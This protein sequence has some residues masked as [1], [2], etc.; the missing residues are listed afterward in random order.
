MFEKSKEAIKRHQH[1]VNINPRTKVEGYTGGKR[2]RKRRGPLKFRMHRDYDIAQPHAEGCVVLRVF[3]PV[4]RIRPDHRFL[5]LRREYRVSRKYPDGRFVAIYRGDVDFDGVRLEDIDLD[6]F[7]H[8]AV[9][10]KQEL[11]ELQLKHER[12]KERRKGSFFRSEDVVLPSN[13]KRVEKP[14][15]ELTHSIDIPR[16]VVEAVS[17]LPNTVDDKE[18]SEAE[19]RLADYFVQK[20]DTSP[21]EPETSTPPREKTL[22]AAL[23]RLRDLTRHI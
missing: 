8:G 23:G 9:D 4:K 13:K 1:E 5:V 20:L 15:S 11:Q 7:Y 6:K 10:A 17:E 22:E 12:R 19:K 14:K 2:K 16:E 3:A 21:Q 18:L